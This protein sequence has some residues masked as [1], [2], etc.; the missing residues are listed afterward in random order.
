MN[1]EKESVKMATAPTHR[2]VLIVFVPLVS[3][4]HQMEQFAQITTNA[5]KLE[6]APMVFV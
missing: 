1:V 2:E 6:C 3:I 5:L 4:Y